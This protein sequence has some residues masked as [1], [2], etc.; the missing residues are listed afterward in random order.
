MSFLTPLFFLL[1]LL[2]GP[3]IILYMLRLRRREVAVSSTLLWRKLLRDR[4]ANAPWQKLRRN[5]LL[6]LQ[7]LILAALVLALARP[8]LLVPGAVSGNVVILLDSSASMQATDVQPSRFEAAR[9]TAADLIDHLRGGDLMTLIQVG[10]TPIVLAATTQDK[11]ALRQALGQA[12]VG[13]GAADWPAA[14]SLAA[15]AAQ[16]F[17]EARI[18]LISD[19]G[20][21]AG[22]PPLTA[23]AVYRPV[24]EHGENLAITAL[25]TEETTAGLE[26]FASV[27]NYGRQAQSTLFSLYLDGSLFD[28]RRLTVA[29]GGDAP[30]AWALPE[31]AAVV[32]AR[33]AEQTA[34]YLALDDRAWVVQ[35][36]GVNNRVL[37]VTPGNVFLEQVLALLP[38]VELFK[39]SPGAETPADDFALYVYDSAS[40]PEPAPAA[41][42][43]LV[44]PQPD[45]SF[46]ETTGVFSATTTVRL[47]EDPLLQFV[48]WGNVHVRQARLVSATW[49][50]PLIEAEGGP[51]L[52]VGEQAGR[53]IAI[54][55]FDLHDSDLPLQVAFPILMANLVG[56]LTPGRTFDAPPTLHPGEPVSLTPPAGSTAVTIT[57]PDGAAWTAEVGEELLLFTGTEQLGLYQVTLGDVS[58]EQAAGAFAVNLFNPSES[59]IAPAAA[60]T[61]GPTTVTTEG[62]A[63]VGQR[64]LWPWLAAVALIV[65]AVEWWVYHRPA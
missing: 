53:R 57:T 18:V 33:L 64:E 56:W 65:L 39:G 41:D 62:T 55:T 38:G 19:G 36:S 5:L 26:L 9:A 47:A 54:L 46:L 60:L 1:G 17:Q 37:L 29:A 40:L 4:E 25:A 2:A 27:H 30:L 12:Q 35:E 51:L 28:S 43:L 59:A 50:R 48:E 31:G 52:L 11:T 34:D 44:N 49:A 42:L 21:P 8:Y 45:S 22:L 16:G 63:G 3:I 10:P 6:L 20:L 13:Q 15:G 61:L 23:E 24:G 58:G 32:E 14:L 7:L